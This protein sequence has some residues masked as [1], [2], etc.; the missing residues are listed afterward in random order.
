MAIHP[1]AIIDDR[2]ELAADVSVGPY[3]VIDGPVKI[4]SGTIIKASAVITGNT[5]IGERCQIFPHAVIG[6][7]GQDKHYQGEDSRVVIGD[8]CILREGVTVHRATGEGAETTIGDRCFLMSNAHVGHN[9]VV[10][11]DAILISGCLLGGHA[12]IGERTVISGNTAIHQFVRIGTLAMLG[13]VAPVVQDVP[14]FTL[15]DHEGHVAGINLVGLK[16][17][18]YT[19]EQ[20][21]EIKEAYRLLYRENLPLAQVVAMLRQNDF[22]ETLQPLIEFLNG[23][24]RGITK[25]SLRLRRAA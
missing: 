25:G 4:G 9:C 6:E 5:T 19:S 23:S 14:P 15:T 17:A 20:R 12:S 7:A 3:V 22:S 8:D 10:G 24:N 11:N 1:T 2:A 16:R 21:G 13:G 18:G